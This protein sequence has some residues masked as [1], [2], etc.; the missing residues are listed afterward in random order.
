MMPISSV[1]MLPSMALIIHL[2]GIAQWFINNSSGYHPAARKQHSKRNPLVPLILEALMARVALWD[3]GCLSAAERQRSRA[4]AQAQRRIL[5]AAE[6]QRSRAP[7]QLSASAGPA[8]DSQR[9]P[10]PAQPSA[11]AGIPS[12]SAAILSASAAERQRRPSTGFSAQPERQRSSAPAQSQRRI[13]SAAQAPRGRRL[14]HR[15][16]TTD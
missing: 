16:E 10:A 9:S 4:P 7:A 8:Q 6:R 15:P 12:A 14:L 5:S 3:L 11:S 2:A 1:A 13:P